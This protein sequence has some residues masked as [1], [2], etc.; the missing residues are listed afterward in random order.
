[1]LLARNWWQWPVIMQST[2]RVIRAAGA[3]CGF[4][5]DASQII[6]TETSLLVAGEVNGIPALAKA[7]TD[8]RP[9]WTERARHEIDAYQTMAAADTALPIRAARFLGADR[10]LPV[11]V[12]ERLTGTVG[13]DDRYPSVSPEPRLLQQMMIAL[14]L[15]HQWA[16]TF[17]LKPVTAHQE[18][19]AAHVP[20]VDESDYPTQIAALRILD[21]KSFERYS[22][23]HA[24]ARTTGP[25]QLHH[26]DAHP[27]NFLQ[28][29]E[30]QPGPNADVHD[31]PHRTL[32]MI[33]LE[34]LA[35]RLPHYDT[36]TAWVLLGD[37]P[38]CRDLLI[39]HVG[40]DFADAAPFWLGALLYTA[41]ELVSHRRWSPT[42]QRR[43]RQPRLEADLRA[44]QSTLE[45]L[46]RRI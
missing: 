27:G 13:A 39:A 8:A 29:N 43:Q 4:L 36:A 18:A 32:A 25:A 28:M 38:A 11:L 9:F 6:R 24:W 5:S 37:H 12:L 10:S 3:C 14:E 15:L 34:F 23:V 2:E 30:Y 45:H 1:M 17:T 20:W 46:S 41:R 26:G 7:P 16:P 21:Q 22:R 40:G 19:S 31:T 44:C 35:L 33:D 42:P